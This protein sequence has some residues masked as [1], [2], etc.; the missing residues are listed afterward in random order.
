MRL[1]KTRRRLCNDPGGRGSV[2][3][4]D[5]LRLLLLEGLIGAEEVLDLDQPVRIQVVEAGDA[6]EAGITQR[7]T[8]DLVVAAVLVGHVEHADG[9]GAD[10]A[11]GEGRLVHD[12]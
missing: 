10:V 3:P 6:L 4:P 8:Q 2:L 9:A 11:T 12:D 1:D 7:Y 5:D